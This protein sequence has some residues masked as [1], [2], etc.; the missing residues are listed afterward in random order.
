M[1]IIG[2]YTKNF[3]L[4]HDVLSTLKSRRIDFKVISN[5]NKLPSDVG[6]ILTSYLEKN[7]IKIKDVVAADTFRDV[8]DA[9]DKAVQ[10]LNG[11]LRHGEII[12]GIDPGE[13]PGIAL[14]G[15]G[16]VIQTW[17][18]SSTRDAIDIIQNIIENHKLNRKIIRIGD[19]SRVYRNSIIDH[20]INKK[21]LDIEIVDET[22]TS[23]QTGASRTEKDAKAAIKIG[24]TPGVKIVGSNYKKPTRG[25]IRI[26][27]KKSRELTNGKITISEDLARDV[28]DGKITLE[29]AIKRK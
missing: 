16:K 2:V 18:T 14:L 1:K 24:E 3:S 7:E 9:I 27:Q 12:I 10:L 17:C 26:I 15:E 29:R 5:P 21:N 4:Y 19:G 23:P 6:V 20:F 8:D 13:Y 28:L 25:E 22:K 11:K